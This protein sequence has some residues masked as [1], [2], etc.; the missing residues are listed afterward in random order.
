MRTGYLA[1]RV[2][3]R[4]WR[5]VRDFFYPALQLAAAIIEQFISC[6]SGVGVVKEN[7]GKKGN[8]KKN[9]ECFHPGGAK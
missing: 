1:P 7:T 3:L 4:E 6:K 9:N 5:D 8:S 2:V